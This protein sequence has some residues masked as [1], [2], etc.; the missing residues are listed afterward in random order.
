[1]F[2]FIRADKVCH[3]VR[4]G[5]LFALL[6]LLPVCSQAVVLADLEG[7][8]S[9]EA[10]SAGEDQS[11]SGT[12]RGSLSV[13]AKGQL[14]GNVVYWDGSSHA[15]NSGKLTVDANG[16]IGGSVSIDN[17]ATTVRALLLPNKQAVVGVGTSGTAPRRQFRYF[18]LVRQTSTAFAQ[19]D[20]GDSWRLFALDKPLSAGGAWLQGSLSIDFNGALTGGQITH[21]APTPADAVSGGSLTLDSSGALSGSVVA[22]ASTLT[23]SGMM[24][25]D[26]N[27]IVGVGRTDVISPVAFFQGVDF[28]FLERHSSETFNQSLL[29]GTWHLHDLSVFD[30]LAVGVWLVGGLAINGSG[31]V[32]GSITGP[33]GSSPVSGGVLTVGPGGMVSGTLDSSRVD[34][35]G[36]LLPSQDLIIGVNTIADSDLP[37]VLSY[38]VFSVVK[39]PAILQFSAA[40]YR[41]GEAAGAIKITV[42]RGGSASSVATVNYA[43]SDGSAKAGTDYGGVSGT[44]TFGAG[45]LSQT[46]TVPVLNNTIVDGKRTVNLALSAPGGGA[47]LGSRA[48]AVITIVDDDIAGQVQFSAAA[49]SVKENAGSATITVTRSGG[50]ASAVSVDYATNDASAVAGTDYSATSGTLTFGAGVKS[51][52]ISVPI[53]DNASVQGNRSLLLTLSNPGGGAKLGPQV[54]ATLT[55]VDDETGFIFS[56]GAYSVKEGAGSA[57]IKVMRTGPPKGT[58]TV[59]YA[60]GDGSAKAGVDYKAVTGT[61]TF[62]AGIITRSFAVPIIANTIV[63]GSRTLNLSLSVPSAGA[64]LGTP[65]TAQLTILDNDVGGKIQFS[66]LN[67]TVK[68]NAG[69]AT[70]T[71]TRSGGIASGV[72]VDYATSDGSAKAGTDY[73]AASGTLTFGA[74][75]TSRTFSVPILKNNVVDG[76][77]TLNLAL[78]TAGGGGALGARAAAVLTILDGPHPDLVLTQ[79]SA[80][81]GTAGRPLSISNVVRN[82]GAAAAGPFRVDFYLSADNTLDAGDRLLGSRSLTGLAALTS[83]AASTVMQVPP[84][85]D[86]GSY[87]IIAVADAGNQITE[88]DETNNTRV[89]A[90]PIKILTNAASGGLTAHVAAAGIQF[91]PALMSSAPTQYRVPLVMTADSLYFTDSSNAQLKRVD[92]KTGN[93]IPLAARIGTPES[94][95]IHGENVF[96]VDG[97]RLNKTA[98]DGTSTTI[99]Q[100]GTRD[101]V[102]GVTADVLVDDANAYWA[103]TVSSLNCSPSCNWVIQR[104]PLAGG[105]PVTLASAT[106]RILALTADADNIYWEEVM[107][108]PVSAGCNCGSS[109][110]MI[111]K[112]GGPVVVLV[113][114]LLNGTLPP[115]PPNSLPASWYPTGG[116]VV[117]GSRVFFGVTGNTS[118][119][120]MSVAIPNRALTTVATVSSTAGPATGSIRGISADSANLYW[121]D[122]TNAIIA[123]VPMTGGTPLALASGVNFPT[124]LQIAA[125]MALW[126]D[127]GGIQGCCLPSGGGSIRAVPVVGGTVVSVVSGLDGPVAL[128]VDASSNVVWAE[129]WRV[130]KLAPG[131]SP[132]TIASGISTDLPRIAAD[133]TNLYVADGEFIKTLPLAGGMLEKL[134]TANGASFS[135]RGTTDPDIAADGTNVYWSYGGGVQKV[136]ASGGT[137]VTL[138]SGTGAMNPMDCY[139]RIVVIG[140]RAYWSAPSSLPIGCTVRTVP[141]AGGIAS[142]LVDFAFLADFATDGVNVYF[143]ELGSNPGSIRKVP[144]EGGPITTV[145]TDVVGEVLATDAQDVYWLDPSDAVGGIYRVGKAGGPAGSATRL[146]LGPLATDPLLLREGLGVSNNI[147][148]WSE[149]LA[150]AVFFV[151]MSGN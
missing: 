120:I 129:Y 91:L 83:S 68:E 98:L 52:T 75:V 147:V 47:Q 14:S 44:L 3:G 2:A 13:D 51:Q 72:T 39:S 126:T 10:L 21:P 67:Y 70:I 100:T 145:I 43:T 55:I 92:R 46:F 26:K 69:K 33:D 48:A 150:K 29:T 151:D 77:R 80:P 15:V 148:F 86:Q 62:G 16:A 34:V 90:A 5:A 142:T 6:A 107:L 113:D 7:G 60:S 8:W 61:L 123:K 23:V 87:Y 149:A 74:G 112:G 122:P 4:S 105:A 58:L 139:R 110:K 56:A 118:Y 114:G 141:T 30:S 99:L 109:I 108:E 38:G 45:V 76:N 138:A 130:G 111:P 35:F 104:V 101:P 71:V 11:P 143:S 85:V 134:T 115:P 9:L 116:I 28:F 12:W 140:Q 66:A 40:A 88:S 84:A 103:N 50:A 97:G 27:L 146:F 73:T 102:A 119:K 65:S 127:I 95:A 124:S 136:P 59:H 17:I 64:L 125:G 131:S 54:K 42:T 96:W 79:L 135:I 24:L 32:G 36:V 53:L 20:M 121:A 37:G 25:P 19:G 78:S 132:K 137:A 18:V 49:Y 133:Q 117:S 89:S 128:A 106:R 93:V 31:H 41:V 144:V 82:L 1:M 63:D 22:G 57:L 81:T 94:V